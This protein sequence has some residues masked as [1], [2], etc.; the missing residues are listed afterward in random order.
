MENRKYP[1]IILPIL[2][3]LPQILCVR[4]V[5]GPFAPGVPSLPAGIA[6]WGDPSSSHSVNHVTRLTK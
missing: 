2:Y 6:E 1:V 4:K 5:N 3:I